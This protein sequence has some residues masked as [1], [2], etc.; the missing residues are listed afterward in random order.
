MEEWEEGDGRGG[1]RA[2]IFPATAAGGRSPITQLVLPEARLGL[3]G[4]DSCVEPRRSLDPPG[5]EGTSAERLCRSVGGRAEG[6]R[7]RGPRLPRAAAGAATA[8]APPRL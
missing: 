6:R 8:A 2:E 4:R 7:S 3:A 1:S 5:T